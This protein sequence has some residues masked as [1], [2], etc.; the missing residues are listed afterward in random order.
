VISD[1]RI[2]VLARQDQIT[3]GLAEKNYVN[4]WILYALYTSELGDKLVFKGGTALSKL[5]FPQL[6]RFSEDLDFT[7]V[8]RPENARTQLEQALAETDTEI[9]FTITNFH[10][11]GQ[12][13]EYIQIDIQYNAVL[14]QK[15][16]TSLD[17]TTNE[18]LVFPIQ[19]HDHSFEDIPQFQLTSYSIEEIFIEKLRSLFQRARA[20][21]YYDIY[22]LLTHQQFDDAEIAE[23]LREKA[24]Q[25][26]VS[27]DLEHGV[28]EQ[29]IEAV[30]AYWDQALDRL[31]A[32]KPEFERVIRQIE[33]Y[34]NQLQ[35]VE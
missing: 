13:V 11:A 31:V 9:N 2:R 26:N 16:T 28:P 18:K 8:E 3:A 29:D 10:T 34:L 25:Q 32:D 5:Y 12:P 33:D 24:Q 6:W 30:R 20:R 19:S 21:D 15:N 17:I 35:K 27:I 4:S 14:G 7:A 22:K 23:A 1:T